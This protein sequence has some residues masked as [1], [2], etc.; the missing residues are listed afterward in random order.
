[1]KC[2]TPAQFEF[3][4]THTAN[5]GCPLTAFEVLRNE[6]TY[7]VF[8]DYDAYYPIDQ[9]P[10]ALALE[11]LDHSNQERINTFMQQ[12]DPTSTYE[13]S[14]HLH[15]AQ[16]HR[17]VI[18]HGK[19]QHKVSFRYFVSGFVAQLSKQ[20]AA[21]EA[22]RDESGG[23]L[24]PASSNF[25]L[26]VYPT[27]GDR[28]LNA[29]LCAKGKD[30]DK[31]P[32]KPM[33]RADGQL[34]ELHNFLVGYVQ[35]SDVQLFQDGARAPSAFELR[36][37]FTPHHAAQGG[38][39][40]TPSTLAATP[41]TMLASPAG[42]MLGTPPPPGERSAHLEGMDSADLVVLAQSALMKRGVAASGYRL[43]HQ[44]GHELYFQTGPQ[45][46]RCL[47]GEQ[48]DSNNF[49]VR[50][51]QSGAM[52]FRCFSTKC[53]KWE[54]IGTWAECKE[55]LPGALDCDLLSPA[56]MQV[57]DPHVLHD[58][59]EF[60]EGLQ[61]Q[62]KLY[63]VYNDFVIW[64]FNRFLYFIAGATPE[65]LQVTHDADGDINSATRRTVE[66]STKVFCNAGKGTF[67]MWLES[68]DRNS[69]QGY[70]CKYC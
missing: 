15:V 33:P 65:V 37:A 60:V 67:K 51:S 68:P 6:Q 45:G 11:A 3:N 5:N 29:I 61:P 64:Y 70:E 30:G 23:A 54:C 48:H 42:S 27:K 26:G 4:A 53:S 25:D 16:R 7:K 28:L 59:T 63:G 35:T 1:M 56:Q 36:S 38:Q 20:K 57:F 14:L 24:F 41:Y 34:P 69:R 2:I 22:A 17:E 52:Q 43:R 8:F 49:I 44:R 12:H 58:A 10:S 21:M 9:Q 62:D 32:L 40:R 50:F 39:M 55:K 13:P 66:S 31:T 19:Q 47:N 46:C 18:H